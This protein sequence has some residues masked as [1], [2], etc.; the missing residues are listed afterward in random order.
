[1]KPSVWII[2]DEQGICVSLSLALKKDYQVATFNSA[3]PA[4]ERMKHESC[5]VVLLDLKLQEEDGMEVL[6]QI[7]QEHPD[8]SVIMMTAFGSIGSSV[9]AIK[10]GAYTYLTKPLDLE[11]L[12][13]F[14]SQTMEIRKM[15]EQIRFLS[16][17]L[18]SRQTFQKIVGESDVMQRVY[19]RINQVKDVDA[20]VLITGE[21][22]TGKELVARAIHDEGRRK[23]ER[24]VVVNC[25]AIPENLLELEFFGYRKGAFT[26]ASQDRKGKLELADK[27]T[28]FLDEIGDMPLNLQ[29]KLLRAL[30]E[31]EFSPVGSSE[32]R[33]TDVRVIAATNQD[34]KAMIAQ[35]KFRQ[36]LYYRLNVVEI[37]MPP[38]RERM[39]DVPLLCA[40]FLHQSASEMNKSSKGLTSAAQEALMRYNYPGNVRQ[41]ANILEYATIISGGRDIDLC[42]LPDE[43]AGG[44]TAA[45]EPA[46]LSQD[47]LA[48]TTLKELE[49]MAVI[50]TLKKNNGR[51][52]KTADDLGISKR[53]LLN[54]IKEY[55]IQ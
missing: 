17:E 10:A 27:G 4:L 22:G 45:E 36:D 2:D 11:Q 37:S 12:K 9:E 24:F 31:K 25:A 18:R 30:Q 8:V 44:V 39:N 15:N 16:D 46:A 33:H 52:D 51:R 32:V 20:S 13:I 29:G 49:R 54:K 55:G 47:F 21:S 19:A 1:M 38:L 53:G 6:R 3:A 43:V 50:A 48:T 41:L 40:H 35:Q 42:D 26:G 14:L 5:D 23:N 7:K 34:L 28:I